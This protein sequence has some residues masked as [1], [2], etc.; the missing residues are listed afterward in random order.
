MNTLE[1][2]EKIFDVVRIIDPVSKKVEY[3][4]GNTFFGNINHDKCF[5]HWQ[6]NTACDNCVSIRATKEMRT[7][8]KLEMINGKTFI[9]IASA[10]E[11]EGQT[12]AIELIKDI[13]EN[14]IFEIFNGF[15]PKEYNKLIDSLNEFVIT[16]E[17][18][19]VY[20]KRY[21]LEHLPVDLRNAYFSKESIAII[22]ADIDDFK[23]INDTYGHLFGDDV[24]HDL[25]RLFK[26]NLRG[27]DD[28]VARYG[29]E[30]F[31]F[32]VKGLDGD[33]LWNLCERIRLLVADSKFESEGVSVKFTIS[34]GAIL[35]SEVKEIDERKYINIADKQLYI[36]KQSG[37]NKCVIHKEV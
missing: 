18:T 37:K 16:D 4:N 24:L 1:V 32:C 15:D 31:I 20:N 17:L 28:W 7:V 14:N 5:N 22:M 25:G 23:L 27:K 12:K 33:S 21:V 30:E 13:T 6:R 2:L 9:V 26:K 10:Y 3:N 35:V 19:Q 11:H 36:A 8:V 34:L 29:G